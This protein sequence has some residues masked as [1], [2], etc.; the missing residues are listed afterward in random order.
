MDFDLL[1]PV[2]AAADKANVHEDIDFVQDGIVHCGKCK[3]PKQFEIELMGKKVLVECMCK[4]ASE[5][6]EAEQKAEAE[7]QRRLYIARLKSQGLQDRATAEHTF[8]SASE[9]PLIAKCRRY[10]ER[11]EEIKKNNIGLL[12]WGN[13][14]NGKTYAAGCIAN[15][16]L[17]KGVSVLV[18][19]F[20]KI[21]STVTGLFG[22]A[23]REY[24][25]SLDYYDLLVLDDLGVERQSGFS[26]E[27]L[28]S[29]IDGRYKTKK[30]LIVTTNL[31]YKELSE[32]TDVEY[33]RIY[34]RLLEMCTPL[35]SKGESL[36]KA[37]AVR[38]AAIG[39][40]ILGG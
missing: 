20:P 40:D 2:I 1:S 22:E 27:L 32:S 5:V 7:K 28:Y 14:G 15:Y 11:W 34:D 6:Y 23:R 39:L 36:R 38:K 19:S 12:L 4:C 30:P 31:S 35:Q 16:L 21:L 8:A 26:N 9:S 13:T 17:D 24:I 18:T 33:R 25:D 10:C 3:T 37:E 29:V